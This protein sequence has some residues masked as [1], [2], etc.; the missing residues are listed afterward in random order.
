M[1]EKFVKTKF[2]KDF[3]INVKDGSNF[4]EDIWIEREVRSPEET[5]ERYKQVS[6]AYSLSGNTLSNTLELIE[7]DLKYAFEE[8]YFAFRL[9]SASPGSGKT[10]LLQFLGEYLKAR[11]DYRNSSIVASFG[12]GDL[13]PPDDGQNFFSKIYSYLL[14]VTF[15]EMLRNEKVKHIAEQ[16]LREL[17]SSDI[18]NSL[19][20]VVINN[21]NF[22]FHFRGNFNEF[23]SQKNNTSLEKLFF[24]VLDEVVK[25][26]SSFTFVYLIDDLDLLGNYDDRYTEQTISLLRS[27]VSTVFDKKYR[28][29]LRLMIYLA[30]VSDN[31]ERFVAK[32]ASFKSRIQKRI[33]NLLEGRNDEYEKIKQKIDER[34][35][36]AYLKSQRLNEISESIQKIPFENYNN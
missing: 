23:L 28:S 24:Y 6:K 33:I 2:I 35:K 12:F 14:A 30:G 31:V 8:G 27:L 7:D 32:D 29:K 20:S 22:D 17:F 25:V 18:F 34:I 9:I 13:L 10:T 15:W 5:G 3:L 11:T 19:N 4:I 36:G 21:L 16:L 26:E 1:S